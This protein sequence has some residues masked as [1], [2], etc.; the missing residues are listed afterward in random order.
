MNEPINI[1]LVEDNPFILGMMQR[2]FKSIP[3]SVNVA[4][5]A[6]EAVALVKQN[7]YQL[8][9]TD[10]GLPDSNGIELVEYIRTIEIK[11]Q[12][13]LAYICGAT[14]FDLEQY[15]KPCFE[16]GFDEL[17]SKPMNLHFI[18]YLLVKAKMQF[19]IAS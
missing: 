2:M 19:A 16:V 7:D 17:V 15:R 12:R 8:I 13:C 9:L 10:I 11:E 6:A 5:T 18:Q 1:L 4:K 3:Q 14:A